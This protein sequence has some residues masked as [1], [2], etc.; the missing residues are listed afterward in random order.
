MKNQLDKIKNKI[1]KKKNIFKQVNADSPSNLS[2]FFQ[3]CGIRKV[4]LDAS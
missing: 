3:A 2:N 1:S 4:K